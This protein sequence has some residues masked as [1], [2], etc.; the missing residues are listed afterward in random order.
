MKKIKVAL[1]VCVILVSTMFT[2]ACSMDQETFNLLASLL[3]EACT[4]ACTESV[5]M[6]CTDD[7]HED[8]V[9]D[10]TFLH[11]EENWDAASISLVK[12]K[13][14]YGEFGDRTCTIVAEIND[15]EAFVNEFKELQGVYRLSSDY[16]ILNNKNRGICITHSDGTVE[17]I[18]VSYSVLF[19]GEEPLRSTGHSYMQFD[20][21]EFNELWEKWKGEE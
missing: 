16:V 5:V 21:K 18:T 4:V 14:P 19:T 6:N 20:R 9:E 1:L 12:V 3:F 11:S 13:N 10:Y 15:S 17:L 7:I 8:K 2:C